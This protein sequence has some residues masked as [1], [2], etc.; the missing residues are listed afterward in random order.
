MPGNCTGPTRSAF[1]K[2]EFELPAVDG[3]SY[4]AQRTAQKKRRRSD[5]GDGGEP[6]GKLWERPHMRTNAR[7][8]VPQI[9]QRYGAN[10]QQLPG[11]WLDMQVASRVVLRRTIARW[12]YFSWDYSP[13]APS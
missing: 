1:G 12:V 9:A 7:N 10:L 13:V 5:E 3:R 11:S 2:V 8:N 4:I 6:S